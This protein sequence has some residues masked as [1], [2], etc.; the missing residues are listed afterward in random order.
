MPDWLHFKLSGVKAMEYTIASTSGLVNA[1]DKKLSEDILSRL[2]IKRGIFPEMKMP[3]SVLGELTE[4]VREAVG[5]NMKVILPPSHDTASAVL[6]TPFAENAIY[7]SSGTWSLMGVESDKP[8]T[9]ETARTLNF[10]NEG[11]YEGRYRFLRNI[12]GLW[13]IQ[14][15]KKE[16]SDKYSFS[17]LCSLAEEAK[18]ETIVD[19]NSNVFLAPDSMIEV[20]RSEAKRTNQQIPETPGELARVVYRSLAVCYNDA[21]KG[22]E[23]LMGKRF[24]LINIVGGGSNAEYLNR[25]CAEISKKTVYAGPSEAT[26]IG[27]IL[28]QML[29]LGEISSKKEARELV[30]NSTNMKIYKEV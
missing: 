6:G 24:D 23:T 8:I 16:L 11:G 1:L 9:T 2:G 30:L 3:S 27:N 7:I 15:L 19:A 25:L 28:S 13:M 4:E 22:I 21:A 10:T 20:L 29:T 14:S 12:M 26:A 5:F 18:I 17:E